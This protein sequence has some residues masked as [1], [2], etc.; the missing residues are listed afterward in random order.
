MTPVLFCYITPILFL[1]IHKANSQSR[2]IVITVLCISSVRLHF[3]NNTKQ[4]YLLPIW[5]WIGR[6][7]YQW[8]LSI[9]GRRGHMIVPCCDCQNLDEAFDTVVMQRKSVSSEKLEQVRKTVTHQARWHQRSLVFLRLTNVRT[10]APKLMNIY[11]SRVLV[12][13]LILSTSYE[14]ILESQDLA[15]YISD[16]ICTKFKWALNIQWNFLSPVTSFKRF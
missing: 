15:Q 8:L 16:D 6:V 7:D 11:S 9:P 4:I 2:S 10:L 5:L 3:S 14:I 1:L 12:G 13:Q